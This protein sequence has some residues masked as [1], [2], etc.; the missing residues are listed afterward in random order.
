MEEIV[1]PFKN[2]TEAELSPIIGVIMTTLSAEGEPIMDENNIIEFNAEGMEEE[3]FD[4]IITMTGEDGEEVNF[5][6]LD[7][8]EYEGK[9]YAVM[10]QIV[11]GEPEQEA[12]ILEVVPPE[13]EDGIESYE[14]VE[15]DETLQAVFNLF[16]ERSMEGWDF[17]LNEDEIALMDTIFGEQE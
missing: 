17:E 12:V 10:A 8:V 2:L 15:D 5:L 9:D 6:F 4:G 13:E 16:Q 7:L 1:S 3:A 11:D 14:G